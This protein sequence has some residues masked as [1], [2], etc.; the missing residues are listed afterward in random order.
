MADFG[1]SAG[2]SKSIFEIGVVLLGTVVVSLPL[3][4]FVTCVIL[5]LLYDFES[6]TATHCGVSGNPIVTMVI[7]KFWPRLLL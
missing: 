6:S 2:R 4:G 1:S 5:S 3:I 7:V